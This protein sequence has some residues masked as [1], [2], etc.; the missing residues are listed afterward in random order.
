M[1]AK[2]TRLPA[3][4]LIVNDPYFSIWCAADRLTDDETRHWTGAEKP[5]RGTAVIDGKDRRFL[6][7]GP[8][9]AMETV[10]LD[11]TPTA[12]RSVFLADGVRLTLT[13]TTPLL[14]EEPDIL[15]MPVTYLDVS[16]ESADGAAHEVCLRLFLS[17]ALCRDGEAPRPMMRRVFEADGMQI[18]HAGQCH[19]GLLCHSGDMVTIDWGYLYLAAQS[20]VAAEEDGLSATVRGTAAAGSALAL[21]ALVAYDDVA[22]VNYFGRILPS[23]YARDGKTIRDAL[24]IFR[25]REESLKAACADLDRRLLE[26]ADALGGEDYRLIV[27]AS[28]RQAVAAHKL[29]ADRNGDMLFLSKENSSNGCVATADVSYPSVPLFLLFNPELVRGMCRPILEFASMPVWKFDFAPHDVGRYP[30]A[31][32]QIYGVRDYLEYREEGC[33]FPP[34][35][36]LPAEADVYVHR[37]Q[38]PVEESG[39]LLLMLCAASQMDGDYTLIRRY[40]DLLQS[41]V[42]YLVEYGEDPAE[43]LCTDDFGGH[44]AHNVNLSAKAICGVAAWSLICRGLGDEEAAD[45]YMARAREMAGS[46]LERAD[47]G[48][49]TYL[50]FTKTGWSMK[51]NMVWD[52][53]LGLHLL[54]DSFYRAE[55]ESYLR[56][57][58]RYGLPLDSRKDY[59]KTD[60]ALWCATMAEGDVFRRLIAPVARFLRES[61]SRVAFTDWYDTKTGRSIVFIARSVQGGLFMPMLAEKLRRR[62]KGASE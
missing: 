57:M 39:N 1:A 35:Y 37:D 19:Q 42:R 32:G 51:Y 55:T 14:P 27:S 44:L 53:V 18:A 6:G 25:E 58:N 43:Q 52:R 28:Y 33:L 59:T 20:G 12:T 60:W 8:E 61:E 56:R 26:D 5:V 31:T 7:S 22:S 36:L 47:A 2:L 46:W 49:Y 13:F 48:G 40:R 11:V 45:E 24:R 16:A 4:P 21:H 54:P 9:P 23:W 15:S 62:E 17:D 3:L 38:M 41:W 34:Y 10:G 29:V 50:T 30:H